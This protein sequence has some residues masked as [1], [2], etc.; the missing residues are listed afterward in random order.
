MKQLVKHEDLVSTKIG[1]KA[2]EIL[3]IDPSLVHSITIELQAHELA[4]VIVMFYLETN[5]QD[6]IIEN[7]LNHKEFTIIDDQ[8]FA[9]AH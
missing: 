4:K 2:C 3:N 8:N 5:Q 6:N 9:A 1:K 7:V